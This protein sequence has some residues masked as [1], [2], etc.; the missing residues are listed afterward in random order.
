MIDQQLPHLIHQFTH[1]LHNAV[2]YDNLTHSWTWPDGFIISSVFDTPNMLLVTFA[3]P[4]LVL[5]FFKTP[6]NRR[7]PEV[8]LITR[9]QIR[10]YVTMS[11]PESLLFSS[12]W[13]ERDWAGRMKRKLVMSQATVFR[14][15]EFDANNLRFGNGP[16]RNTY[17]TFSH[18]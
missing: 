1:L 13:S 6:R 3:G 7:N 18:I 16:T 17:R 12:F 8:W 15:E 4:N 10:P 14:Y 2:T 9:I 5:G 11:F